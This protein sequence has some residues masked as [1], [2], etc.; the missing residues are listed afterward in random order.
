M[1]IKKRGFDLNNKV[2][3]N[4][5]WIVGCRIIQSFLNLI[6][7]MLSARYLGPANYGLIN[8]AASIVAFVVPLAGLGITNILVQEL[9]NKPE[10][11][12]EILGTSI[13][14]SLISSFLCSIL[15]VAFVFFANAG[16]T[17]TMVVCIIYN[18]GLIFQTLELMKYWYQS[19][20]L[21]KYTAI[22]S[23]VAYITVALYKII[24]LIK[25]ASVY[26]FAFAN[27]VDYI[28]IVILLFFIY[29]KL[30]GNKFCF[31]K[32][33]AKQMLNK[34]KY[35]IVSSMMV[36]IYAQ[37]D[38]IM[39]KHMMG[40][41]ANGYYSA[42]ITITTVTA[43]VFTAII[44]SMRPVIFEAYKSSK[45]KFEQNLS[46]LYCIIIY[47]SLVQSLCMTIFSELIVSIMYGNSY[48]SASS[49]L[50]VAVW[51]CT[52]SYIGSVRNI[53]MLANNKQ[54][55]LWIINLSGALLN[56]VLNLIMIRLYGIIGAAIASFISQ[57]FSNIVLGF[58]IRPLRGNTILMIRSLNPR[59]LIGVVNVLKRRN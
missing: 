26:Y 15:V 12:G 2:V 13:T 44:D 28:V 4:A 50:Q 7:G 31:S 16:D 6:V 41:T 54:K 43:F 11:E 33:L 46:Y 49:V 52:F 18:I 40:D 27:S 38:K 22:V 37:T 59:C 56:V 35:Y 48:L 58:V 55:Y 30:G 36:T 1:K 29:K 39:I 21:S 47:M 19:K 24:L 57:F 9:V 32:S 5:S 23:L 51:Y 25:N 53:W 3:R 34:G 45:S 8:Y 20:L 42:G 14:L 17:K 10:K